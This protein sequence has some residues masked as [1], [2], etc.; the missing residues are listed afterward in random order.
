MWRDRPRPRAQAKPERSSWNLS[1]EEF[2][3]F[4]AN[5]GQG[6]NDQSLRSCQTAGVSVIVEPQQDKIHSESFL[7]IWDGSCG[8]CRRA[9]GWVARY[10]SSG[11][12]RLVP[13]QNLAH[14]ALSEKL[15]AR[16]R[17]SMQVVDPNGTAIEGAAAVAVIVERLGWKRVARVLRIR[18]GGAVAERCYQWL[19]R[20][21]NQISRILFRSA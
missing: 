8:I 12:I 9:A 6:P 11:S 20:H 7:I 18:V 14:D 2:R 13:Y 1:C 5:A 15:A 19:V 3:R 17:R 21:R 10:D 4:A 16:C